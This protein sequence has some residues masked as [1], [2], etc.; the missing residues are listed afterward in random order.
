MLSG[1]AGGGREGG[2][3]D[4]ECG[5]RVKAEMASVNV[6]AVAA[7]VQVW[8]PRRKRRRRRPSHRGGLASTYPMLAVL[9]SLHVVLSRGAR[10]R[11]DSTRFRRVRNLDSRHAVVSCKC[12]RVTHAHPTGRRG[13][14]SPPTRRPA[15]HQRFSATG[16]AG[17]VHGAGWR[18][19]GQRGNLDGGPPIRWA[20]IMLA[21]PTAD[22][23][24]CSDRE[25]RRPPRQ[26]ARPDSF[27]T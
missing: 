24:Q 12:G 8:W 3:S 25:W 5:G 9:M 18:V 26:A 1:G 22:S 19:R 11:G 23:R 13:P 15:P 16:R 7:R 4:G 21:T 10:Q 6:K 17:S 20:K 14:E 27:H 2:G